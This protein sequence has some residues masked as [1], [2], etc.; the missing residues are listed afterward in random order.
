VTLLGTFLRRRCPSRSCSLYL[1]GKT[2]RK[3]QQKL[4][5]CRRTTRTTTTIA[6][7]ITK[8]RKKKKTMRLKM[9]MMR[10]TLP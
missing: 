2:L 1:W 9:K 4:N 5:S 10:T 6:T 7:M 8:M 3:Q